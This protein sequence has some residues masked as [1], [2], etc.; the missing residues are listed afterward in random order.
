MIDIVDRINKENEENYGKLCSKCNLFES[1]CRCEMARIYILDV[2]GLCHN[3]EEPVLSHR[4][5]KCGYYKGEKV[6]NGW[7]I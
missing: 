5:C 4:V 2:K 3:C 7:N 1:H 6:S